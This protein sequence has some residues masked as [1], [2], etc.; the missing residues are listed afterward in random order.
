MHVLM[1]NWGW[2]SKLKERNGYSQQSQMM[3]KWTL[4][5]K[6]NGKTQFPSREGCAYYIPE[7]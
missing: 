4:W 2:A 5:L 3:E 6:K 7:L 1:S